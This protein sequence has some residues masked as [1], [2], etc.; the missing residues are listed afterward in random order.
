VAL[1]SIAGTF[2]LF[3]LIAIALTDVIAAAVF[4]AISFVPN[5]LEDVLKVIY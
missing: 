2:K 5:K 3:T 1:T 4:K